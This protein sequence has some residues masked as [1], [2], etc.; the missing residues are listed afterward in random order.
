ACPTARAPSP[1]SPSMEVS[2]PSLPCLHGADEHIVRVERR[3]K[4]ASSPVEEAALQH[5]HG[6]EPARRPQDGG[7]PPARTRG[8]PPPTRLPLRPHSS[9]G[10]V[11]YRSPRT[12]KSDTSR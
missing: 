4:K 9:A 2:L 10:G 11:E 8:S 1:L 12:R 3:Q 6:Q 5:V 7:A